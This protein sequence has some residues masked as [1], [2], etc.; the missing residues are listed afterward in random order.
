MN[1]KNEILKCRHKLN[2]VG[3]TCKERLSTIPASQNGTKARY[4]KRRPAS[5]LDRK[6]NVNSQIV[7]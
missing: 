3:S 6:S 7:K 5:Y 2:A 4:A 1:S